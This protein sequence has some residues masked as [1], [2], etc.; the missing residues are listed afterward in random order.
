MSIGPPWR[1]TTIRREM[2]RPSPVP[3]PTSLV[4]KN[5]SK[6]RPRPPA[7]CPARCR[8][9]RPRRRSP[10]ARVR[11]AQGARA[12][13][14]VDGVVDE[15]G[16]DL[17]ELAGVAPRSR[18]RR[19]RSRATTVTP[20]SSLCPSI[21]S[22]LSS[23]S[24][25]SMRCTRRPVELGVGAHAPTT[26][27][28]IR[29]VDSCT[30]PSRVGRRQRARPPTPARGRA[31]AR[32]ARRRPGRTRRRR[33][34]PR[35][36]A[37]AISQSPVD[38]VV[39]PAS[40]QRVLAVGARQ[41]VERGRARS[42]SRRSASRATNWSAVIVAV[43]QPAQRRRA[44]SSHVSSQRVDGAGRRRR[45]VVDLVGEPGGQRAERDQRLALAGRRLDARAPCWK[46]PLDQV[47]AEREPARRPARA[48]ARRGTRST[49]PAV[50]P[51]PVAR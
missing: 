48:A 26:S 35:P 8:R 40:R 43:G 51:R 45:R 34:R 41:R 5:G 25:T 46:S 20:P 12:V 19:R 21:T 37:A 9:S 14:R 50:A 36:A 30:S 47:P 31:P 1:S 38:A 10:S 15:V 18:A 32:R 28:E 29:R 27:S 33:P 4:V 22:V 17:V 23:P 6:A 39:G 7:A 3:L 49:R 44:A 13:H 42:I 16:P 2:S 11:D 24:V